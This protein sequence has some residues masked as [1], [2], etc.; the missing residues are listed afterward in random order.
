MGLIILFIF[1]SFS[2]ALQRTFIVKHFTHTLMQMYV[3]MCKG[4]DVKC[5]TVNENDIFKVI[6]KLLEK[7]KLRNG[8]KL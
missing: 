5:G 4:W 7:L 2:N 8:L 6:F 1:L 3:H